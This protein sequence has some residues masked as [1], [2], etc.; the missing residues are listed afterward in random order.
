MKNKLT[1][2]YDRTLLSL[3]LV[4]SFIMILFGIMQFHKAM[5]LISKDLE[6]R[7]YTF[8]NSYVNHVSHAIQKIEFLKNIIDKNNDVTNPGLG[9]RHRDILTFVSKKIEDNFVTNNISSSEH[10]NTIFLVDS[11]D[12]IIYSSDNNIIPFQKDHKNYAPKVSLS[13]R[14]YLSKNKQEV[15][16]IHLGS[17]IKG[18]V[19]G[20]WVVPVSSAITS[21]DK[22]H[23]SVIFTVPLSEFSK[24]NI[25]SDIKFTSIKIL[26][27][28]EEEQIPLFFESPKL[29]GAFS[30]FSKL[31]IKRVDHLSFCYD[32]TS[33]EQKAYADVSSKD[34]RDKI[35]NSFISDMLLL[36]IFIIFCVAVLILLGKLV[37]KPLEAIHD[38]IRLIEPSFLEL[39]P[40]GSGSRAS[41]VDIDRTKDTAL[42]VLNMSSVEMRNIKAFVD[43]SVDLIDHAKNQ[44][45]IISKKNT[46]LASI[47][48]LHEKFLSIFGANK[49]THLI[50]AEEIKDLVDSLN[51]GAAKEMISRSVG[52]L[53]DM[54]QQEINKIEFLDEYFRSVSDMIAEGKHDIDIPLVAKEYFQSKFNHIA[55]SD[56]IGVG[57]PTPRP[58][59]ATALLFTLRYMH[60]AILNDGEK[61]SEALLTLSIS[62]G[63]K[64][65][66]DA[67][68]GTIIEL[69]KKIQPSDISLE[70]DDIDLYKAKIYALL[71][72]GMIDVYYGSDEVAI[73][74]IL[75]RD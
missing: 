29:H 25:A 27:K 75:K 30:L 58:C 54:N 46:Q 60:T 57:I 55:V 18:A 67:D 45:A 38:R 41:S 8:E 34:L 13:D 50:F 51:L 26:S 39:L 19:T 47:N 3:I 6:I 1:S 36:S 71:N 59:F 15:N 48:A 73:T 4:S 66:K 16:K 74:L 11:G 12:K 2:L 56:M 53:Y 52:Q 62:N 28:D 5:N 17:L 31:F 35:L 64:S 32:L 68:F 65:T 23:G 70:I 20:N 42:D 14:E 9:D 44:Q 72:D 63:N 22:Y 49:K 33:L 40:S 37:F 69:S 10:T 61:A 24:E 21:N 7:F 43:K